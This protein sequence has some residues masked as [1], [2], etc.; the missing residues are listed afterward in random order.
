MSGQLIEQRQVQ[1]SEN[2]ELG[3]EYASGIYN[4][5]VTQGAQVKA[6]RLIK[7]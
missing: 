3:S 5:I 2:V 6:L 1:Q 7:K 4:V